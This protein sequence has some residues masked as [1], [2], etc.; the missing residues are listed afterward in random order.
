MSL[1]PVEKEAIRHR[2]AQGERVAS[3]AD[4]FDVTAQT[5]YLTCRGV[6]R[7]RAREQPTVRAVLG[8]VGAELGLGPSW[9]E[10]SRRRGR[11]SVEITTA[12]KIAALALCQLGLEEREVGRLLFRGWSAQVLPV[13]QQAEA[14]AE[15]VRAAQR[16]VRRAR[17]PGEQGKQAA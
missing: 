3:L 4:S 5:I 1:S 8:L 17:L 7:F 11:P 13:L 14:D 15:A 9:Q 10:L 16:V 12:R 2:R 6:P